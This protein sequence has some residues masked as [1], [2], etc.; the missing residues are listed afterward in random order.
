MPWWAAC[1]FV[2]AGVAA[3]MMRT[4]LAG[5]LQVQR[6]AVLAALQQPGAAVAAAAAATT[7]QE[8]VVVANPISGSGCGPHIFHEL[9]RPV[10]ESVGLRS[11]L[12]LTCHAGHARQIAAQLEVE[13]TAALIL[14]SGDG[15]VHEV[16]QGL[17]DK[18]G[19]D[20]AQL[21]A[22]FKR[23]PL[24]LIP[25]GSS[26][27]LAASF[28]S[29]NL[30]DACLAIISGTPQPL[31][32]SAVT[33]HPPSPARPLTLFDAHAFCAGNFADHDRLVEG[34]LRWLGPTVK[35]LVGAAVSIVTRTSYAGRLDF[36]PATAA[37][38]SDEERQ[39]KRYASVEAL[40]LAKSEGWR[41]IEGNFIGLNAFN[42]DWGASDA[43]IC[44]FNPRAGGSVD[45]LVI[46]ATV[47]VGGR[48]RGVGRW[49]MVQ[50]FLKL[51]AGEHLQHPFFE[52]YRASRWEYTP[53]ELDT[54]REKTTLD[55]SGQQYPL[56]AASG[57]VH[58]GVARV[59][60]L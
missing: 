31:D 57:I 35:G 36:L 18:C 53:L 54:D 7:D 46:R 10:L 47:T 19:G 14:I 48:T 40:P 51:E 26:N 8:L 44:P 49:E 43:Y 56:S 52:R 42:T 23:V 12:V 5:G 58:R 27:G 45:L 11:R 50:A 15:M 37:F 28:G 4:W 29:F 41:R 59:L 25:A 16:C 6:Q 32:L 33:L 60:A 17:A 9:L 2:V 1:A 55:L 38:A 20:V 21:R 30:V 22:L 34:K 24:G 13:K 39:T 3:Q